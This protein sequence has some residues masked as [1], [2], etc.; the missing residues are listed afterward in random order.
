[1]GIP[2]FKPG[3]MVDDGLNK[4]KYQVIRQ[5]SSGAFSDTYLVANTRDLSIEQVLKINKAHSELPLESR[6]T[7]AYI[8]T[9]ILD[10]AERTDH[11][12][13][14]LSS[15][16]HTN[17][18]KYVDKIDVG[19]GY[20][21]LLTARIKGA[22]ILSELIRENNSKGSYEFLKLDPEQL[23]TKIFSEIS[24]S[25]PWTEKNFE[26][27]LPTNL[28]ELVHDIGSETFEK[29]FYVFHNF[30][31]L[32][33]QAMNVMKY[34]ASERITHR[35]IGPHNILI[36]D[37]LNMTLIDFGLS[38]PYINEHQRNRQVAKSDSITGKIFYMDPT[39]YASG[40]FR[41]IG[42]FWSWGATFYE[43][44][45]GKHVIT[46]VPSDKSSSI[47]VQLFLDDFKAHVF[48]VRPGID[49]N[50][51]KLLTDQGRW[52]AVFRSL[53]GTRYAHIDKTFVA[54]LNTPGYP[55]FEHVTDSGQ[56]N[57][58]RLDVHRYLEDRYPSLDFSP[59]W[60][61][62]GGISRKHM[63]ASILYNFR[64]YEQLGIDF[65]NC[66]PIHDSQARLLT[67][68]DTKGLADYSMQKEEQIKFW[69]TEKKLSSYVLESRIRWKHD[70]PQGYL[71][72]LEFLRELHD[73]HNLTGRHK[74][75]KIGR[76]LEGILV[77]VYLTSEYF[78]ELFREK[79]VDKIRKPKN[80]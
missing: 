68:K 61:T 4:A 19:N 22:R 34:L 26:Y 79:I 29:T 35:D 27:R 57:I 39:S 20:Q 65:L 41:N 15:L 9:K 18:V 1:M 66:N 31:R 49:R 72:N 38:F 73:A 52:K 69:D 78:S 55:L 50:L 10:N 30:L 76:V 67:F 13:Q 21:G 74:R 80:D 60:R 40:I 5:M 23:T 77:T 75:S 16:N 28:E 54:L 56:S 64:H 48:N 63:I 46:Q 14:I 62:R 17:I 44:L 33:P 7:N 25:D 32:M 8:N 53:I 58:T 43:L 70:D 11:E 47:E 51:D 42:D 6:E 24:F 3:D 36:D 59:F 37:V 12:M 2:V 45:T 71:S